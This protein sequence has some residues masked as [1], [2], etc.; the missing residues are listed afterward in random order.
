MDWIVNLVEGRLRRPSFAP[1]G[2]RRP[3]RPQAARRAAPGRRERLLPEGA[4]LV[5]ED[6]GAIPMPLA[7]HVTLVATA[8]RRS[9]ARSR[10]RC[11]R[12]VTAMHGRTVYAPLPEGTRRRARSRRP[13]PTTRRANGV[14]ARSPLGGALRPIS[15]GSTRASS[16]SC[17]SSTSGSSRSSAGDPRLPHRAEHRER[18]LGRSRR[19]VARPGRVARR[20]RTGRGERDRGRAGGVARRPPPLGRRRLGEPRR[21]RARGT[22]TPRPARRPHAR[23]TSTRDPGATGGARNRC[24]A[25]R[26]SCSTSGRG[27][28]GCSC[29]R[30]SPT[31]WSTCSSPRSVRDAAP[32]ARRSAGPRRSG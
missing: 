28:P 24:S 4:Q 16:R 9:G 27:R 11:S 29:A 10:S 17:R 12:A 2:R 18:R 20:R 6:T 25:P 1:A 15:T 30:P 19:A 21:D 7:G 26:R 5:L 22:V 14:T 13:S 31:T 3:P 8:A 23:S 32:S